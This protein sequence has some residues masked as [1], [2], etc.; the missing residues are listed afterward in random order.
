MTTYTQKIV[1]LFNADDEYDGSEVIALINKFADVESDKRKQETEKMP[2]GKFRGKLIK[3][4]LAFDKQYLQWIVEQDV[5][6]NFKALK[7]TIQALL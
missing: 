3:D 1:N 5:M 4:I 6:K 7:E 2:F